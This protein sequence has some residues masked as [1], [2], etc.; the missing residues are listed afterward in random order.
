MNVFTSTFRSNEH[1]KPNSMAKMEEIGRN[2]NHIVIVVVWTFQAFPVLK[3][4][5]CIG[6]SIKPTGEITQ[7]IWN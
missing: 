6:K 1:H 4:C 2:T 7:S 3:S 5:L